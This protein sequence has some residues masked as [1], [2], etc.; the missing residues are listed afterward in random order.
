MK[1]D[2]R[3]NEDTIS[4]CRRI[5]ETQ[6]SH[7]DALSDLEGLLGAEINDEREHING[8]ASTLGPPESVTCE[9]G[10]ELLEL[11]LEEIKEK[12]NQ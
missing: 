3:I 12:L 2:P 11:F 5:L 4:A 8:V 6:V 9:D 10:E 1:K 7:W